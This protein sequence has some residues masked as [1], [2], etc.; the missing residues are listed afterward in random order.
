MKIRNRMIVFMS[1][2]VWVIG[3][4]ITQAKAAKAILHSFEA[5]RPSPILVSLK[6]GPGPVCIPGV[7]GC[8]IS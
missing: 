8:L 3:G 6:G 7:G 2:A 5:I 4:G 1:V